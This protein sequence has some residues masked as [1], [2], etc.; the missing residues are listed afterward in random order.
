MATSTTADTHPWCHNIEYCTALPSP[1][2]GESI[3]LKVGTRGNNS[4]K[5]HP[6]TVLREIPTRISPLPP[7]ATAVDRHDDDIQR[8][9][10]A[11]RPSLL[12]PLTV[13]TSVS[14][15]LSPPHDNDNYV[16]RTLEKIAQMMRSWPS[17]Q[18]DGAPRNINSPAP[19]HST[20]PP[21]PAHRPDHEPYN[22]ASNLDRIAAEVKQM[23]Q[24]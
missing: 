17:P 12:P 19:S 22:Y 18:I 10:Q 1:S 11:P 6:P 5:N 20:S 2:L 24:R 13:Q 3:A 21:S 16:D 15:S 9:Q 23:S 4:Q 8:Q 7:T 14:T